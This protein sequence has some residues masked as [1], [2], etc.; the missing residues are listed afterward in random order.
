M[1]TRRPATLKEIG[2]RVGVGASTA[3]VVLN[4]S[5]SGTKVSEETRR[6]ILKAAEELN[7]RPNGLAR[8]LRNRRT[9]IVGFF[10]GYEYID[11]RNSYIAE[12]MSGLQAGCALHRLNLLLYTPHS[13]H[14]PRDVV[15]NLEDGRLD[16]L[17]ITARPDHPITALLAGSHLPVVAIADRIPQI[18]TV[19]VDAAEGGRLQARHLAERGH[20]RVLY[21]PSDYPF[22]SVV[23]RYRSFHEEAKALGMTVVD[24]DPVSG[25]LENAALP[26]EIH[27]RLSGEDLK[28]FS[29]PERITAIQCWDDAP[30]YRV[31]TQLADLGF[32]VPEDVAVAGYNGCEP[33]VE[34]R[35]KLTTIR[36]AWPN[37]GMAAI[38]V[39]RASIEGS[40][41]PPETTLP[42]QLIVGTTT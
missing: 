29:G 34:P 42:V 27:R 12:V 38:E 15:A 26:P 8:S 33:S 2:E 6:A 9:G 5:K 40:A 37:V 11:P 13:G 7:Y 17:I 31:A 4:G 35:W 19:S 25:H 24:G 16:G 30:A 18:P 22:P 32:R 28:R 3:S 14:G 20:R 1:S 10:S 23:E 21:V 41:F 36:A 39:L